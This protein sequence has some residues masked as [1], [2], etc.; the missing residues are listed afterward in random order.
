MS[1]EKELSPAD[2]AEITNLYARYNLASDAG[3]ADEYADCF[4]PDG[5]LEGLRMTQGRET[6]RA[7]KLKEKA[8]R[9]NLYRQHWNGSLHLE[10][11]D[12]Q[13]VHGRC[14]FMAFNGVPEQAPAMSHCGTYHDVIVKFEGRWRFKSRRIQYNF[15]SK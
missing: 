4:T 11:A 7:Y 8:A 10:R 13:T 9:S 1:S 14:Y 2:Q 3:E 5:T 15:A 6:L 12:A